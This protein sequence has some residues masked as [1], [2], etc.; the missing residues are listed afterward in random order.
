MYSIRLAEIDLMK[1]QSEE[2][3]AEASVH[4]YKYILLRGLS[5]KY[6]LSN[7]CDE[8]WKPILR[9]NKSSTYDHIEKIVYFGQI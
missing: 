6:I 8:I 9:V 2:K 4:A 1:M 7:V 3:E 5:I